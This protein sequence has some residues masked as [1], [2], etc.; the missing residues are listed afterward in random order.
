MKLLVKIFV[1]TFFC[2]QSSYAKDNKTESINPPIEYEQELTRLLSA[3]KDVT[4]IPA[5]SVAVVHKGELVASVSTGYVDTEKKTLATNQHLFR[6]A[7]VS[8]IIGATMLAELVVNGQLDP[9]MPIGQYF[10]ELDTKYQQITLRQLVSH[11]S[12]M[13]HYQ[14]KDYNIY[15]K[16]YLSAIEAIETL[17]GRDLLSKPGENYSYSTH[18]YTLAGAI[19]ERVSEQPLSSS[20]PSFIKRWTK[21]A[22]P[23]IENIENLSPLT[24][25]IFTRNGGTVDEEDFGEK[26]YSIFGAGL[27]ATASDLAYLGD[28][29]LNR[30]KSNEAYRQLLFTPTM[31]NAGKYAGNEKYQVGFGW[32]IGK[33]AQG[34]RVYH[35]AGATPGAR[36]IIVLYP[37]QDISITI[38]SNSSWTSGIDK[39]AFSL[40]GLYIDKASYKSFTDNMKY[41]VN[42]DSSKS[43]GKISCTSDIC[44]LANERSGYSNWLNKFNST[45][46]FI[47][48]WPIFLYSSEKGDRLLM[49]TKVGITSLTTNGSHYIASVSKDKIYSVR[50]ISQKESLNH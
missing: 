15:N 36:S 12:G 10:P 3:L 43:K 2:L 11:T 45:G 48:N 44:F 13:P 7:S 39:M 28:E 27:S 41:E 29:V 33:D 20:I 35:H 14:I 49:V 42:Y 46:E 30:S 4:G 26:S 19:H 25:K 38:L 34:R 23:I 32:R 1:L 31:T 6:L 5:F 17:K 37:E 18:G 8:K 50:L 9:D 21:K 24:S 16:H 47:A 22:T 40:A